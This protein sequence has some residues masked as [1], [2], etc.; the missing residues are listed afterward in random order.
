MRQSLFAQ[1]REEVLFGLLRAAD[2]AERAL[3]LG[4]VG[5]GGDRVG[6]AEVDVHPAGHIEMVDEAGEGVRDIAGARRRDRKRLR[7]LRRREEGG[8]H[9]VDLREQLA[10]AL[11]QLAALLRRLDALR[12]A[13]ENDEPEG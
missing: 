7:R 4:D 5:D 12:G 6:L 11:N 3:A 1:Q 8:V 2:D 9:L 13:L 10:R